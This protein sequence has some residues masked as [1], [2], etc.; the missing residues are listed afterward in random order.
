MFLLAVFGF[1]QDTLTGVERG[2]AYSINV[3]FLERAYDRPLEVAVELVEGTA[4]KCMFSIH[5]HCIGGGTRGAEGATPP[6]RF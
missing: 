4:S 5:V 1:A 6:P 3:G 2:Q